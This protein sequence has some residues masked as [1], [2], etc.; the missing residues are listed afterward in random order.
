[1]GPQA[2]FSF[3]ND[4]NRIRPIDLGSGEGTKRSTYSRALARARARDSLPCQPCPTA[5]AP[6]LRGCAAPQSGYR[7]VALGRGLK[8]GA[9]D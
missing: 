7:T 5:R 8:G 4:R 1:M 3:G 6:G 2:A 9:H